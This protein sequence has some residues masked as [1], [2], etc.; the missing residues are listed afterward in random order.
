MTQTIDSPLKSQRESILKS[1]QNEKSLKISPKKILVETRDLSVPVFKQKKDR[2]VG[3]QDKAKEEEISAEDF[4]VSGEDL[5][6]D[7]FENA[8]DIKNVC[9]K[10]L[11]EDELSF[12]RNPSLVMHFKNDQQNIFVL[13]AFICEPF[14]YPLGVEFSDKFLKFKDLPFDTNLPV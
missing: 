8:K 1:K 9:E 2:G 12:A 7:K 14:I 3:G 6:I 11:I 10:F 4:N 5:S 13:Y